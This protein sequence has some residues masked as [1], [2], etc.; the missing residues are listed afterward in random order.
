[1]KGSKDL[2]CSLE[3]NKASRHYIGSIVSA[4]TSSKKQNIPHSW[5]H[6]RRS[7]SLKLIFFS[8]YTTRLH[9]STGFE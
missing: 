4:M 3:F 2:D 9:E 8:F 7:P 6:Q 1:M 5:R